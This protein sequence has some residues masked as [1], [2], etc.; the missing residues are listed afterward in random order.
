MK[1]RVVVTGLG[2]VAPN[3]IGK[4]DFSDAIFA[5]K[6]GI[7][8]IT[9]LD[10]SNLKVKIAGEV[11]N[12]DPCDYIPIHIYRKSDRFVHL[13]LSAT[14]LAMDDANILPDSPF[15]KKASVVIGSGQGGLMFHEQEIIKFVESQGTKK[16]SASAVPRITANAI[17]AY[18]AIQHDVH[19][20]YRAQKTIFQ[21]YRN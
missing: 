6:S 17:S 16:L 21:L 14:K 1:R 11:T 18:I 8:Q 10:T 20:I 15:L 9:S 19:G 3:G 5:G 4:K 2:V 7:A 13:G 12:F